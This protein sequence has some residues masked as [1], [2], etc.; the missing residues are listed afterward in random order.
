VLVWY[1]AALMALDFAVFLD[2][3]P[4]KSVDDQSM[5][6]SS[7]APLVADPTGA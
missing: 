5:R 2:P 3:W 7:N 1:S 4:V 6:P